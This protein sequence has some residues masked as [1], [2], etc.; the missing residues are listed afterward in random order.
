MGANLLKLS[1][2]GEVYFV[3]YFLSVLS[4]VLECLDK[5]VVRFWINLGYF[6]SVFVHVLDGWTNGF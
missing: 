3:R 2:P 1:R 5:W 6:L 4:T